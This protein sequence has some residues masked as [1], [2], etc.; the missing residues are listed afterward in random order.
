MS[1]DQFILTST[2]SENESF[3]ASR[4]M[5][6]VRSA[7]ISFVYDLIMQLLGSRHLLWPYIDPQDQGPSLIITIYTII[8]LKSVC[9]SAFANCRSQFLLDLLGRCLKLSVSAERYILPRVRI[10]VRS[11]NFFIPEKHQKSRGNRV[12]SACIY[13]NDLATWYESQ[14]SGRSQ[15]NSAN[16]YGGV[17]VGSRVR[18]HA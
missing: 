12:G 17:C 15:M 8:L 1:C 11:C 18:G 16:L 9:L 2:I 4:F 13:L 10:S 7:T 14:R 6:W 5:S 3:M